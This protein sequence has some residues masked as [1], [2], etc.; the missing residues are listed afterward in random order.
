MR[1]RGENDVTHAAPRHLLTCATL[2]GAVAVFGG[3]TS[4]SPG[5]PAPPAGGR[6]YVLDAAVYAATVAP[7]LTAKGCDN[8]S[9]HGGGLRGTFEL[10]PLEDKDLVFDFTQAVRQVDP[11]DP[12]ASD[13]LRKPLA[14]E[15]GGDVHTADSEHFGFLT[16][17][18]PDYQAILAW[19]EAGEFR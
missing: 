3:C 12:A 16:T 10:S 6:E 13:L 17:G 11:N 4:P 7:R 19:I 18:D 14:P 2:L 9:C 8:L 15:A 1:Q 5:D